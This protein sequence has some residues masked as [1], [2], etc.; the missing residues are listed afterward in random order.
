MP[1]FLP[2]GVPLRARKAA[3]HKARPIVSPQ[4]GA[5]KIGEGAS[6]GGI[7]AMP[8]L[9]FKSDKAEIYQCGAEDEP[10]HGG[11]KDRLAGGAAERRAPQD[12]GDGD[13]GQN[14][15]S[16]PQ[17]ALPECETQGGQ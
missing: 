11:G 8:F 10:D 5:G 16:E 2:G 4:R 14:G 17:A 6:V 7:L 1:L 3:L 12:F 9:F 15:D 13:E